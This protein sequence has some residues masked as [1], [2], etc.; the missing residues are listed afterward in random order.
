MSKVA[1]KVT[2]GFGFEVLDIEE[3]F[4]PTMQGAVEG[5]IQPIDYNDNLTIWVNEEFY[6]L[7]DP[8][9]NFVATSFY[10]AL[11]VERPILGNAVFTGGTDE[12]GEV[13]GLT[14]ELHEAIVEIVLEAQEYAATM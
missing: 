6:S 8:D 2:P 12:D 9:V 7:S 14:P 13:L 10:H 3:N 5:L 1:I 4:L 11:G